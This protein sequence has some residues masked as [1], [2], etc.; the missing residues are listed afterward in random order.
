MRRRYCIPHF[1]IVTYIESLRETIAN[2]CP[3]FHAGT[4]TRLA[5][6]SSDIR[7]SNQEQ[8]TF[9]APYAFSLTFAHHCQLRPPISADAL[10]AFHSLHHLE[11]CH[12]FSTLIHRRPFVWYW[13]LLV[14]PRSNPQCLSY[15]FLNTITSL[16]F[17]F[18]LLFQ[19]R[20]CLESRNHP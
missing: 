8:P 15:T 17:A 6:Q 10:S 2:T 3:S 20:L 4:G 16:K 13:K 11:C 18:G 9:E 5:D 7:E 14:A 1:S 12:P 19:T